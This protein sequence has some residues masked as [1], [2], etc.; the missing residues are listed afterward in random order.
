MS[1]QT[2]SQ[3]VLTIGIILTALG[4]FGSYHF[5]KKEERDKERASE[6]AQGRLNSQIVELQ[7]ELESVRSNTAQID[8]KVDLI[9]KASGLVREKWTEIQLKHVPEGVTDYVVLLFASDK[10][11]ITGRV[12]IKGSKEEYPFSTTA[13][14]RI[15]VAVRNLWLPEKGHYKGS[16]HA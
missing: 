7:S 8:E 6:E 10:G 4:G 14:D 12:R 11:R 15:P 5:G 9:F 2:I 1:F 3:I 13:N 16:H